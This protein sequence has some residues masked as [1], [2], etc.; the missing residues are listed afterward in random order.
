VL[1]LSRRAGVPL[2]AFAA[3]AVCAT[4]GL[5]LATDGNG[6]LEMLSMALV[7]LA[8]GTIDLRRIDAVV[9]RP[10]S[11]LIAY[12]AY[13]AVITLV[14]VPFA[15]Q[16]IGVSL[17]ILVLYAIG[18]RCQSPAGVYRAVVELGKYSLFAYVA[19]IAAL[20]ALRRGLRGHELVGAE[21]AIPF[22]LALLVTVLAVQTMAV[23]RRRSSIADS[24]YR[25]VFA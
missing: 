25:A 5:S 10:V 8:A 11:L 14:N 7:G 16:V 4:I 15:L 20:Q 23:V 6:L 18:S 13:V 21:L 2:A 12:G 3:A 1:A 22:V 24:I 9:R 19:Q 17:S